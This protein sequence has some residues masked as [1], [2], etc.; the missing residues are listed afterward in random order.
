MILEE[1]FEQ[2]IG[3]NPGP[4]G[5]HLPNLTT[6]FFVNLVKNANSYIENSGIVTFRGQ[7]LCDTLGG[8]GEGFAKVSHEYFQCS[9][10]L[11]LLF[12]V[13]FSCFWK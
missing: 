12:K 2:S 1:V 3:L 6:R 4:Q 11:L 10:D 8:R 7:I 5:N 13:W 9:Q